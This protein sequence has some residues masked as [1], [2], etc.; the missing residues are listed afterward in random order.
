MSFWRHKLPQKS[1]SKATSNSFPS[2][3]LLYDRWS[4]CLVVF[5]VLS[6]CCIYYIGKGGNSSWLIHETFNFE[7]SVQNNFEHLRCLATKFDSKESWIIT[8]YSHLS[9]SWE[10]TILTKLFSLLFDVLLDD[11][12]RNSCSQLPRH[13]RDRSAIK[14]FL[15]EMFCATAV[16]VFVC[17]AL[18]SPLPVS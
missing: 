14:N 1:L 12:F 8:E 2:A 17:L 4:S 11:C 9:E 3:R 16:V 6:P 5:L 15:T 18:P 7:H 10:E 13:S